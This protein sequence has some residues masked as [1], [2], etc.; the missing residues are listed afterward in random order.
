M[1]LDTGRAYSDRLCAKEWKVAGVGIDKARWLVQAYHYSRGASNTRTY[2]HGLY[3]SAAFWDEDCVGVAWWIPPTRDAA[4]AT[5]PDRPEG[6]LCLSRLVVSP[7]VPKNACSFLLA[8]SAKL[9][10]KQRWP[11]LVTYADEWQGHTGSIY[12]AT[13]WKYVG[14]TT[15]ESTF[16]I[17][18]QMRSRKAGNRTRTTRQMLEAGAVCHGRHSKHK[19]ILLRL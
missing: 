17:D 18:G 4:L 13:N 8:R 1:T 6:V 2:L 14:Q 10:P 9:I 3:P 19:Y 12:R 11:C 5:Y 7:G 15:P 16:S